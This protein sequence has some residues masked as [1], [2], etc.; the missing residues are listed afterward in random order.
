MTDHPRLIEVA[1]PLRQASLDSVHEKNVR[2]GHISTLHIWPARRPLA[3]CR[4][5]LIA[6]LLP[7][8]GTA[9]ERTK[10]C[11]RIG[12]KVIK[13]I[14]RKKLPNGNVEERE[15]EE[16]VGG[17]LHWGR[18]TQNKADLEWFRAEIRKAHGDRAPRVLDPFAGG[19]AIPLEAM[20]LGCDVTAID[21]NSV[22]W[23]L[24]KCTLEY[25]QK[26]AGQKA[27]LPD[28]ILK[29]REFMQ[30]FFKAQGFSPPQV[31]TFLSD[32]GFAGTGDEE[33][34][35][36]GFGFDKSFLDADLAWQVRAW[37]RWVL[38]QA[39]NDLASHYPVYAD[40]EPLKDGGKRFKPRPM[41]LVPLKEDGSPDVVTLNAELQ[42]RRSPNR[43]AT[44]W[45]NDPQC[46]RWVAKP[47]VAYLWARTVKCKNCRG[48]IPLLKTR[49]LAKKGKKRVLLRMKPNAEKTGVQ[50][51]VDSDVPQTGGN[52]AVRRE[53]DR[54]LGQGTMSRAGVWCPCCGKPDTVAMTMEDIRAEGV[55]GRLGQLMTAVVVDGLKGKEYRLPTPD[56]LSVATPTEQELERVFAEVPFGMPN[57][58]TPAGGGSGAGR[59]FS[60]QGYGMMRWRDVFTNRQLLSLG[61]FARWTHQARERM[62]AEPEPQWA[63]PCLGL[64]A[65]CVDRLA[66]RNSCL[67]WWQTSAEKVGPTFTRFA[68]PMT[69]DFAEV[70][71]W[72]DSSG[73]YLQAVDWVSEVVEHLSASIFT[74]SEA[75]VGLQSAKTPHTSLV[76][77]VIT[78]PPYYDAIPYSDLMDFYHIWLRRSLHGLSEELDAA[79]R[80][81]LGVKWD[82]GAND[83]ELVDDPSRFGGNQTLS[84]QVYEEGM[85]RAFAA[86]AEV[87]GPAGRM[88]IVFANKQPNAWETLVSATIRSGFTVDG[89]WPIQTERVGRMRSYG[90]A[91]L[92]SS[93]WLVCKKRSAAALPGW[94]NT[95]LGEMKRLIHAQLRDFWD[96]GIR[97]PDFVWAATGPALEAYSKHP[98][99]KKASKS[100]ELMSVS[101]FL[102]EVRRIVVDFVVGRVLSEAT[103]SAAREEEGTGLDDVTTYYL[104]HR[105]DFGLNDAPAGACI[106]YAVSCNLSEA[107]L[108]DRYDILARTGGTSENGD[109]LTDDEEADAEGDQEEG[110]GSTFKLKAWKQRNRPG[111]GID[112]VADRARVQRAQEQEV[113]QEWIPGTEPPEPTIVP[114]AIP[115]IDQ[116]HRLMH[117][118]RAGDQARVNQ[119]VEDRGLRRSQLFQQLLQA[120][121]ELSPEGSDERSTLESIMNHMRA[122]GAAAIE[123]QREL[124]V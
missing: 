23:F 119:Y 33:P 8:P 30:A 67:A 117:L 94:D 4:A 62:S 34:Q 71:P 24:L 60:V 82:H 101:E 83:G 58:P 118:W 22:A 48:T 7:D 104:L 40:F 92:S 18:E 85:A 76:D 45:L 120:L 90:S 79:F 103:H 81:P 29:D 74:S 42:H 105:H 106:L 50:F 6:T 91:S 95:V 54:K 36:P 39:Q 111:M 28:F 63:A 88:V 68:L 122:L 46:P 5:A 3:A 107:S 52:N 69:W 19:G 124:G 77:L 1:F 55:A 56:E 110:T 112:P 57:E 27:R 20:R 32:L 108:A 2:H 72:A 97:G 11:E 14:R 73:G 64:L 21:I 47:A 87:L 17:I 25:P 53:L 123:S 10:L 44:P 86:A 16:T 98:I 51:E 49:W 78:D 113:G 115:L 37:G 70:Q 43:A 41:Q 12:G 13:T 109:E 114:R 121:V 75:V 9:E 61:T 26:L 96:S 59:A 80:N 89:S 35:M 100:G 38:A 66:D 99:V 31:R 84:K 102:R 93:V 15:V 65:L 116:A